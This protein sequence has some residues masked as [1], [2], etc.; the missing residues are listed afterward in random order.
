MDKDLSVVIVNYNV[1]QFLENAL[2]SVKRAMEGIHGEIFVVDNASD[3]GSVEMLKAKFPEVCLIEN[4]ENVGFARANNEALK[5]AC[6]RYFL[7]LNPD[8]VVQEDTFRVLIN[9][10]DRNNDVGLAGCKILNPD[11][12]FQL[13]CRRSFPTP[14][15]A[16][17]K[18]FGLSAL[19]PKSR[20]FGRYNLTYLSPD[21][22][23]EV[24]AVS[25]SFMMMTREAYER[26]GGLDEAFFMYGE[27]LDLCYRVSKIGLK[28]YYVHSTKI[29]HYKGESTKRSQIDEIKLFYQA[30]QLF[31]EKHFA[32][33]VLVGFFLSVGILLRRSVAFLGKASRFLLLVLVDFALVDC[34]LLIS[35]YFR[36]GDVFS[37]PS[38]AYPI[39]WTVPALIVVATMYFSGLYTSNRFSVSRSAIAVVAS[40]VIISATVFFAK[41]FAF[42]RIVVIISG[43]ISCILLPGWRLMLRMFGRAGSPGSA[44][45]SL[46]GRRTVIVGTGPSGQEVLRKLRSRVDDG[47]D[48]QGFVAMDRKQVGER[49]GGVEVVG[50]IDNVGKVISDRRVGEV[51]F[52]TDGLSYTD[53]LSVIGRSNDRS[54]NFRLVPTSLEAI[55][56]K[57]RIDQLDNIPLVEIQYNIHKSVNRSVKRGFDIVFALLFLVSVY[58]FVML[59]KTLGLTKRLGPIGEKTLL[60]PQVLSGKRSLVGRPLLVTENSQLTDINPSVDN[61]ESYLGPKGLTGLVQINARADLE[62]DEIDR[63]ELYYAKNQSFILDLEIIVKSLLQQFKK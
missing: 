34:A 18:I 17:T 8:T 28:V 39:V 46:F 59:Q 35:E 6:G 11:G 22:T 63:Y 41:D 44:R 24:D 56:G 57:T 15:V 1:R 38:Y 31:V 33:S 40:Y 26:V 27:D 9:F 4:E 45:R 29:I 37:F 19:F 60:L 21:E 62:Q 55:I 42:S 10:F 61:Q 5:H 52:S 12:S 14:W 53:I 23:Y 32:S 2:T 48:V 3:D 50:S 16:F 25:G 43:L 54:V 7:L 30:M 20:L 47:Y 36:F 51:I 13:A 49:I 58:P